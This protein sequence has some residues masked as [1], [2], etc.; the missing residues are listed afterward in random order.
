MNAGRCEVCKRLLARLEHAAIWREMAWQAIDSASNDIPEANQVAL[1]EAY[2][3]T[4]CEYDMNLQDYGAH[5][6]AAHPELF[7][8]QSAEPLR[9][10]A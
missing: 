7:M 5:V 10:S 6:Q 2:D 8:P 1:V 9:R 4:L 3:V